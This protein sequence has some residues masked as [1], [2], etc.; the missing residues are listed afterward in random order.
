MRPPRRGRALLAALLALSLFAGGIGLGWNLITRAR[1]HSSATQTQTSP[2]TGQAAQAPNVQGIASRVDPAV[3]DVNTYTDNSFGGGGGQV[4]PLGAGTGVILT[5]SG[6]VLTN[7]HVIEGATS[8]KITVQGRSGTLMAQ[9][10]GADPTDDVALLQIQNV[11]GLSTVSLGDS[12][13]LTVGQEVIAIGNALGQ[14]GTPSATQGTISALNRSIS[15]SNGRGG[16]EHL[17]DLIQM[18]A[19]I[20]PGDSGGPLVNDAGQVVG[21]ITAAARSQQPFQ[22]TSSEGFAI[23]VNDAIRVVNQIRTG[24]GGSNIII[25]QAGF[26]GVQ[27]Q[28]LDA[29][30]AAQLGLPV[31]SGALVVGV[32]AGTPAARAGISQNSVIT[33]IDGRAI[34]STAALGPAIHTHK[35]GQQIRVTWV[36]QSGTHTAS[37]TLVAG[38]AV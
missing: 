21:L 22:G 28:D 19:P 36:D 29:A 27:V 6:E 34:T 12:S 5:S 10:V 14:G 9:V 15:V 1:S 30:T 23:P 2:S 18:D 13:T 26:L 3:V 32:E 20:A 35:P 25:G 24:N 8:I 31:S 37:V 16:F 33:A 4:S 11:S 7:N 38:P 17:S